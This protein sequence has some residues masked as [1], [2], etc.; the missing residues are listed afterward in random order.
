MSDGRYNVRVTDEPQ[1]D[2][3]R[4]GLALNALAQTL[5]QRF[6]AMSRLASVT[7][8]V[9]TGIM[10]GEVLNH[11]YESFRPL[12]PYD[13]IG[14]AL[15]EGGGRM[16]RAIWARSECPVA[17]LPVGYAAA[18]EGSSLQTIL[19]TGQPR[20]LSDLDAYLLEHP[21]SDSTRR[22]VSE[23]LRA[24]L[25]CPLIAMGK[26]IGFIFFSSAVTGTY[27]NNHSDLFTQL[28]G[29]LAVIVEKARLYEQLLD[30]QRQLE[31]ANRILD[32]LASVDG[33]T[34]LPNRRYFDEHGEAERR[35]MQR[36]SRPLGLVLIDVDHFKAYNDT[37]G[38][39]QGDES[40]KRVAN[41]IRDHLQRATDF[42]ARYGGEEFA[43]I[44]TDSD[45]D[46]TQRTADMLRERVASLAVP[47]A[48]APGTGIV[49]ISAGVVAAVPQQGVSLK[50]L[51]NAADAA[52]Y[53]SKREGRNRVTIEP[54]PPG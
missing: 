2:V 33:L 5:E 30:A 35:R 27:D 4:L 25:T 34:G 29:Q 43:V 10:L 3:G 50:Q 31:A 13:R 45:A 20:I 12:L 38:H 23:G 53:R 37:Y 24:S 22:I 14:C 40:L 32:R 44:L 51:L 18:L 17:G 42:V 9:N 26:P 16:V 21:A 11:V 7:A 48:G 52:L 41:T 19:D 49:T 46:S 47:H 28:A 1:D 6:E 15:L 54:F 8:K 36:M 39:L